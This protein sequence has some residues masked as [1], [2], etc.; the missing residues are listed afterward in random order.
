MTTLLIVLLIL[1]ALFGLPLFLAIGGIALVL[2]FGEGIAGS[3]VVI[4]MTRL[5]SSPMLVAIP[6]F[7]FAGTM[8]AEGGA[9]RRLV[10]LSKELLGWM[11]GGLALVAL[12]TCAIF[13]A[14]TGA[15]G[16]T[17]VAIGGLL[18]PA[19]V[20]AGY[21]NRFALGLCTTSG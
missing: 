10:A 9:P 12:A 11:P 5:A 8:F 1:A 21:S 6:L 20:S 4:E 17:I 3:A 18:L 16:V 19:L 2:F 15:S 7:T 14:F 13:T